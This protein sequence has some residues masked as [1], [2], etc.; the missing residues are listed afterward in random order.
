MVQLLAHTKNTDELILPLSRNIRLVELSTSTYRSLLPLL[1]CMHAWIQQQLT[2]HSLSLC[3]A[4][5]SPSTLQQPGCLLG[6]HLSLSA[7]WTS[8]S[9]HPFPPSLI[10]HLSLLLLSPSLHILADTYRLSWWCGTILRLWD[11]FLLSPLLPTSP[12][13]PLPHPGPLRL[14]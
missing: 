10:M 2:Q 6:R 12:L 7:Q 8:L 4:P 13:G 5:K 9:A 3:V 1:S 11:Q 14:T